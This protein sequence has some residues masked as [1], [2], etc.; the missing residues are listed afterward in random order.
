MDLHVM[1]FVA[2]DSRRSRARR[3]AEDRSRTPSFP[4]RNSDRSSSS[5][6]SRPTKEVKGILAGP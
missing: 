1:A 3:T 6:R 5:S 2:Y 4:S